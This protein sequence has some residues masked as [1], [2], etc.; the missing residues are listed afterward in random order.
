M[1][2][3]IMTMKRLIKVIMMMMA[4][5]DEISVRR[6]T[7][8]L[9]GCGWVRR[10]AQSS[11]CWVSTSCQTA[12]IVSHL[13]FPARDKSA[14]SETPGKGTHMM[15]GFEV[16]LL[17]EYVHRIWCQSWNDVKYI[18]KREPAAL[19]VL[20]ALLI[21]FSPIWLMYDLSLLRFLFGRWRQSGGYR[22][23]HQTCS[24]SPI[25]HNPSVCLLR[26]HLV[27]LRGSL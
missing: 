3:V 23:F 1:V 10:D 17:T 27:T 12:D 20:I 16:N 18:K 14:L 11:F 25:H 15:R 22:F 5:K 13:A 4:T 7:W 6:F 21:T 19:K 2:M 26:F 8:A 24:A 9:A